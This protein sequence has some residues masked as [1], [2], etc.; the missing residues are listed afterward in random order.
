[1]RRLQCGGYIAAVNNAEVAMQQ[2]GLGEGLLSTR[3]PSRVRPLATAI[4]R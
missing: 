1:M 4:H 3:F 2:P